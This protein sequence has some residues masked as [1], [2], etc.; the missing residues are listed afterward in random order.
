MMRITSPARLLGGLLALL[1]ASPLSGQDEAADRARQIA[2]EVDRRDRGFGDSRARLEMILQDRRGGEVRRELDVLVLEVPGGQEKSLVIFNS[3]RDI[4]G[5]ALLTYSYS[6]RDNEQ[7][8]YLPAL[9]RTK[10]ISATGRSSPF[11]GSEFA[12][13]DLVR[14]GVDEY[15]YRYVGEEDLDGTA[16]WIIERRPRYEGTG[17]SRERLWVDTTE[18]RVL[19]IDY[20]DLRG[21]DLKTL[22]LHEYRQ[23]P[24][25]IWRAGEMRMRNL[26][27]GESTVLLWHE[28][29]FDTG[30][31]E[32]D[33]SRGAL[34]RGD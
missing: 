9:R 17:Y 10:R 2:I 15:E 19:R 14:T 22:T 31:T 29:R 27:T 28:Y 1:V 16:C 11:M 23:Y 7:W 26:R 34:G 4:R 5:T 6:D 12:Y 8:L 13:E 21:R 20:Q 30:L 3:P 24:N 32:S 33:F 25:G 18:Y